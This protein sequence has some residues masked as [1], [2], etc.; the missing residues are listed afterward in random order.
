MFSTCNTCHRTYPHPGYP[1]RIALP[2]SVAND[3]TLPEGSRLFCHSTGFYA[4]IH[5]P[6]Y[7][8]DVNEL[9]AVFL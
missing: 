6:L 1:L 8:E 9:I 4:E 2:C 7:S 3:L 5:F